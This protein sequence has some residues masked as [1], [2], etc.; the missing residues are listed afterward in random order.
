MGERC[1]YLETNSTVRRYVLGKNIKPLVLVQNRLFRCDNDLMVRCRTGGDEFVSYR[2]E[3][4][5]PRGKG[6]FVNTKHTMAYIRIAQSCNRSDSVSKLGMLNQ[7]SMTKF[8]YI[9]IGGLVIFTVLT[10][11]F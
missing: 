8:M 5:Q 3:H 9:I 4:A 11:G 1:L 7:I 6:T 2:M 10:G